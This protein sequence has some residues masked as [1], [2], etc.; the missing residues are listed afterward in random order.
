MPPVSG[1][2]WSLFGGRRAPPLRGESRRDPR[3]G[4]TA[5][6]RRSV[7]LEHTGHPA[8][9]PRASQ[10]LPP[11]GPGLP[12]RTARSS[13]S[14]SSRLT[15]QVGDLPSPRTGSSQARKTPPVRAPCERANPALPPELPPERTRRSRKRPQPAHRAPLARTRARPSPTG[16]TAERAGLRAPQSV[17]RASK[18]HHPPGAGHGL[19]RVRHAQATGRPSRPA[20]QSAQ[21]RHIQWPP[22]ARQPGEPGEGHSSPCTRRHDGCPPRPSADEPSA[23]N[24]L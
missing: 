13:S 3:P 23:T 14:F 17:H 2:P 4:P 1:R 9:S 19:R 6:V 22:T 7:R 20:A 24:G 12:A 21:K 5:P 16:H 10:A 11:P 15:G 8:M 18:G